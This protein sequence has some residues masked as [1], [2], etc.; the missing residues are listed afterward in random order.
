ML[1]ADVS[2]SAVFDSAVAFSPAALAAERH[3]PFVPL[4]TQT[5]VLQAGVATPR[6]A[7]DPIAPDP[8]SLNASEDPVDYVPAAIAVATATYDPDSCETFLLLWAETDSL[9]ASL[10]ASALDLPDRA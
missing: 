10:E 9:L 6:M 3:R 1:N 5:D 2:D 4:A 8:T 7:V